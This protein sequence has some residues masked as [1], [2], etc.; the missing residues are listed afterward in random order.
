VIADGNAFVEK[1][2]VGTPA[3]N[4][5]NI[6]YVQFLYKIL[7]P[8]ITKPNVTREKLL[9]FLAYEKCVHKMLMKLTPAVNFTN[10]L[11]AAFVPI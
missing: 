8:K 2:R 1:L 10:I 6:L 9:N 5:I 3:V 4:F 11:G 7:A